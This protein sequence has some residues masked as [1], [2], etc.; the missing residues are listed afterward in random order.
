VL[1]GCW[2]TARSAH[3][4]IKMDSAGSGATGWHTSTSCFGFEYL[5]ADW[6]ANAALNHTEDLSM[7]ELAET[8]RV[9][10]DRTQD[11]RWR[12]PLS[13][14]RGL[15]WA[16]RRRLDAAKKHLTDMRGEM[17]QFYM[18]MGDFDFVGFARRR[19]AP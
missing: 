13:D 6:G 7:N 14:S 8:A 18:A 15:P 17:K 5:D 19:T 9:P 4:V 10:R 3:S 11:H 12:G 16:C 1:G 2:S